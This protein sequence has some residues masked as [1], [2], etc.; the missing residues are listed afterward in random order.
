MSGVERLK[1]K[2][3]LLIK[4]VG[5]WS[6][7]NFGEQ[8]SKSRDIMLGSLA[9]LLG[10]MEEVG[11]LMEAECKESI[12]ESAHEARLDAVGDILIYF[13]DYIYREE[14]TLR[15]NHCEQLTSDSRVPM[16]LVGKLCHATLK[17]HQGIRGYDV[18][19]KYHAEIEKVATELVDWLFHYA[20][21]MGL[22]LMTVGEQVWK[23]VVSKRNWKK[24]KVNG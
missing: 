22:D 16:V 15:Y 20:G 12:G 5:M 19:A 7:E 23:T 14:V 9:P 11:E 18:A 24:D 3:P 13:C 21:D 2:L 10:I 8:Q 6:K 17:R 4:E 1:E